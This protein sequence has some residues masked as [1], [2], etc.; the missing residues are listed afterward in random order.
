MSAVLLGV[1]I[2]VGKD[3]DEDE[4]T[5]Q[6]CD[7]LIKE[8]GLT[9]AKGRV[10]YTDNYY[11][12]MKLAKHIFEK[13]SWTIVG[14]I[15]PT[16]K[17]SYADHDIPFLKLS[18]GARNGLERGWY[19]KSAIKLKT[20]TSK[21]YYIQCT[22]WRDK[23]QVIFLSSNIVG[24]SDGMTVRCNSCG[25]RQRDEFPGPRAQRDYIRYFNA[26]DRNDRDSADWSTSF[27]TI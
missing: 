19:H 24:Y 21:Q 11:T 18:N 14:T 3:D 23:K 5:L 1:K 15:V 22:T 8:A 17:K 27:R 12:S 6:V 13:Y 16:N 25:K 26:V 10:L 2:Y 4:T 7:R 20:P 9:G